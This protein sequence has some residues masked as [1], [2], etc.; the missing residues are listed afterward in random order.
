MYYK[1]SLHPHPSIRISYM[2]DCFLNIANN[3][4]TNQFRI[5]TT[6]IM[7]ETFKLSEEI[8][9]SKNTGMN[10]IQVYLTDLNG[11]LGNIKSYVEEM[12]FESI[13]EIIC[14]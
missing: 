6:F 10:N 2:V 4:F 1:E 11:E 8:F 5:D 7:S 9:K 12:T 13:S 14:Y 3:T